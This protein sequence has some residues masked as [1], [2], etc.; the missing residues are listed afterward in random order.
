MSERIIGT[1]KW[2]NGS[3][4]YGFIEREGGKDV[5]VHFSAIQS[6]GFKNLNEGQK[7]EFEVEQGPKGPQ[8][9]NVT[10]VA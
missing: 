4:G 1:V 8:A 9:A 3:K 2:F 7:V 10:L 5:F 6:E